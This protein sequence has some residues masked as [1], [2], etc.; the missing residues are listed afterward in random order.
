MKGHSR[1]K[2]SE[3]VKFQTFMEYE[4]SYVKMT[5][6]TSIVEKKSQGH[7]RSSELTNLDLNSNFNL[8]KSR[9]H[10]PQNGCLFQPTAPSRARCQ[11]VLVNQPT[12]AKRDATGRLINLPYRAKPEALGGLVNLPPRAKREAKQSW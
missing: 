2:I 7:K 5:L 6:L 10:I 8:F 11:E 9:Q 4:K 1:S 12:R 3:K